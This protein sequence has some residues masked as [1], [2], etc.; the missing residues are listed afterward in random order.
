MVSLGMNWHNCDR[1]GD[2]VARDYGI[3]LLEACPEN[4]IIITN[5][6]NDTFPLWFAQGVLGVRRDVIISN[7]SL[8][9][10]QWYVQ[11]LLIKDPTL[12]SYPSELVAIMQPVF[13]WG[14]N[15]FH[16]SVDGLPETTASDRQTLD[17]TFTGQWPW[18][19]NSGSLCIP[20][21][22]MGRG[23][24]GSVP[25]QDLL[26]IDMIK[27]KPI[28]GREIM[29]AGTVSG[30]NRKYVEDYLQMQGIAFRVMD[31]PALEAVDSE[32][33]WQLA[34]NLQT[35][36]LQDASVY[37]GDQ[38]IQ[39]AR[40]YV[41]AYNRLA[42]QFMAEGNTEMV[43]IC[44]DRSEELFSAMPE[45][46][47]S[48]M[49]SFVLLKA[50]Y[51]HGLEG[52]VAADAYVREATAYMDSVATATGNLSIAQT[53]RQLASIAQ[54]FSQELAFDTLIDS[55]S[56]GSLTQEWIR[57]EKDLSFGN[58]IKARDRLAQLNHEYG[59]E[60]EQLL[61]LMELTV[62]KYTIFSPLN[63]G[64]SITETALA[65]VF[66][67]T[68]QASSTLAWV[69]EISAS[70]ILIEM[71]SLASREGVMAAVSFGNIM[72]GH[73][74]SAPGSSDCS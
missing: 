49:P 51:L 73:L 45:E 63:S 13:V 14:P 59:P 7:L 37:K 61:E 15:F 56:D 19:L 31:S 48:I 42:Y 66:Q 44:L 21:P 10:T 38:A 57:I 43:G 4:G 20:V 39:I 41:S 28:H 25:M 9:N 33:G 32:L 27:N 54:E 26:L 16:V 62:D 64:L 23:N 69:D 12:L 50:R 52:A 40:N 36:G 3:N 71:I 74:D 24:Q 6:D 1:S 30:E 2:F 18:V 47:L 35:T 58:Y 8:M 34:N 72:A 55:I 70:S 29:I 65:S 46:W 67:Y 22:T 17:S 60:Y 53:T 11:Q 5:G 68:D